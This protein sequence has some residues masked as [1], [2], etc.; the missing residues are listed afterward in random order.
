MADQG[1]LVPVGN[2]LYTTI[3][4]FR[5]GESWRDIGYDG[6]IER[7]CQ[8]NAVLTVDDVEWICLHGLNLLTMRRGPF[9]GLFVFADGWLASRHSANRHEVNLLSLHSSGEWE[10]WHRHEVHTI[11]AL[12]ADF[13]IG[14]RMS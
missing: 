5:D 3:N 8:L 2:R 4:P 1:K 13:I 10:Y 12:Y 6:L 7:V 14:R 11:S 9:P